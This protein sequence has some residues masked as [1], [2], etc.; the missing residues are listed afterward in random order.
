MS[1]NLSG[2]CLILWQLSLFRIVTV[3]IMVIYQIYV[4]FLI[5]KLLWVLSKSFQDAKGIMRSHT[6]TDKQYNAKNE[7]KDIRTNNGSQSITQKYKE[8]H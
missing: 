6:S 3:K 7:K 1:N 8:P 5:L 4:M 2:M